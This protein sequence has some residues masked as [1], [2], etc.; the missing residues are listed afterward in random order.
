[1]KRLLSFVAVFATALLL[2]LGAA[3]ATDLTKIGVGKLA[4]TAPVLIAASKGYFAAENLE[5]QFVFFD[6]AQTIVMGVTSGDLDFGVTAVSGTFY[7]LAA[8]GSIKL[9]AGTVYDAP[10]FAQYSFVVSNHAYQNG[11]KG[12]TDLTGHSVA[13]VQVGG[14]IHYVLALV[15]EKYGIDSKTV[16]PLAL[17]AIP[18]QVSAVTGGQADAGIIPST[19][20]QP[21]IDRGDMKLLSITGDE[22]QWQAGGAFA[23]TKLIN[24]KRALVERFLTAFRKGAADYNA[25]FTGPDGKRKDGPT[26][27]EISA[28]IGKYLDQTP[29]QIAAAIPYLDGQGRLDMKDID[30]QLDWY[31]AQG[32]L[33]SDI[34]AADVVEARYLIERK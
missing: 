24:E 25:A 22:V 16:K 15:E 29:A 2:N 20:A 18:N 3:R 31:R 33:K 11:L 26:A 4:S 6:A 7:S 19:A 10:G 14:P 28:I 5:P 30:H 27:A 12:Y 34:K 32:M 23:A 9:I 8:Q 17:Q 21:S 13:I 1:M